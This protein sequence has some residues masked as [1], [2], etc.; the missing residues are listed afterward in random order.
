LGY[1]SW[2]FLT[3]YDKTHLNTIFPLNDESAI[4]NTLEEK[5]LIEEGDLDIINVIKQKWAEVT[6]QDKVA[7]KVKEPAAVLDDTF[8]ESVIMEGTVTTADVET[9]KVEES[10]DVTAKVE[11]EQNVTAEV[12][13]TESADKPEAEKAIVEKPEVFIVPVQRLWFGLIDLETKQ[14][15]HYSISEQFAIDVA[16]HAWLAA[17]SSAPFSLDDGVESKMFQDA[18]EHYFKIDREGIKELSKAEYVA[19]GGWDQW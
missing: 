14:K 5:S 15:K 19:L 13:S 16:Q 1:A 12:E 2:Y 4:E 3:Q 7:E 18:K 8:V 6:K 17:T 10:T 9:Q 11:V